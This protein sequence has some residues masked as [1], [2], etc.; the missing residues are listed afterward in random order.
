[1]NKLWLSITSWNNVVSL[2]VTNFLTQQMR[3]N[4][5]CWASHLLIQRKQSDKDCR[6]QKTPIYKMQYIK[7]GRIFNSITL[8]SFYKNM[9][10]KTL[11]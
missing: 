8:Q 7:G 5:E 1:M 4:Q 9:F 3:C 2:P 10:I 11:G 6:W